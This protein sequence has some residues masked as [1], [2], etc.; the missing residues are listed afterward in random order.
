ML[1]CT[2]FMMSAIRISYALRIEQKT[3]QVYILY[4]SFDQTD[5]S[6]WK[7]RGKNVN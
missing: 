3:E 7:N 2:L 6:L 5:P 1:V 4:K